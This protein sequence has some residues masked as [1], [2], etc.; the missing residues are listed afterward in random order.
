[1]PTVTCLLCR[2]SV[3]LPEVWTRADYT[4]PHCHHGVPTESTSHPNGKPACPEILS[5]D[6]DEI[7]PGKLSAMSQ[8]SDQERASVSSS[9]NTLIYRVLVPLGYLAF[10][11]VPLI[12]TIGFVIK[13]AS[14]KE[15]DQVDRETPTVSQPDRYVHT[16]RDRSGVDRTAERNAS[17]VHID[18]SAHKEQI[19]NEESRLAEEKL[20][21]AEEAKENVALQRREEEKRQADEQAIRTQEA[22]RNPKTF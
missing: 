2:N 5:L 20:R 18:T 22:R 21:L 17:I 6:D 8:P 1:M 19:A 10:V 14:K 3:Q 15:K 4:C 16:Q 9:G 13:N 12:L 11:L 7:T